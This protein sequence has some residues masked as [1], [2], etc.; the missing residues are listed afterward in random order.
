M[1]NTM[2][3]KDYIASIHYSASDEIFYGKVE[4]LTDLLLFEGSTIEELKKEFQET[5]EEY[6]VE[7]TELGKEPI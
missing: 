3:Y 4:G 5:I 7:C 1:A 2:T 6:I